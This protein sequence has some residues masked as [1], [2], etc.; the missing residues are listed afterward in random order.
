MRELEGWLKVQRLSKLRAIV[1]IAALLGALG[2]MGIYFNEANSHRPGYWLGLVI[3]GWFL[4]NISAYY[5]KWTMHFG[6]GGFLSYEE[7]PQERMIGLVSSI[8]VVC[9]VLWVWV[10]RFLIG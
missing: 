5:L 8:V 3:C 2:I 6:I 10:S 1:G 4:Y 9:G 7:H